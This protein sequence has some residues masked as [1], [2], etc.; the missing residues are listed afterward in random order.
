MFEFRFIFGYY[1]C[2]M[3]QIVDLWIFIFLA[4]LK[5]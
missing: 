1:V 5:L 2:D 3:L 4:L